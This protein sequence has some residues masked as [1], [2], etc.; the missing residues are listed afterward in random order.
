MNQ[1]TYKG[2]VFYKPD[3]EDQYNN[4]SRTHKAILSG[5]LERKPCEVCGYERSI[6][7]HEKYS[8][9][10][11][12]RWLCYSDHRKIHILFNK[13]RGNIN[14]INYYKEKSS[15]N[16]ENDIYESYIKDL[17]YENNLLFTTGNYRPF[18]YWDR[19]KDKINKADMIVNLARKQL[20]KEKVC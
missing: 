3:Y 5:E 13:I 11:N 4:R 1:I 17:E 10:L 9:F 6:A 2:I 19:D 8:D 15:K 7:H 16:P 18:S 12:V 14:M 20:L